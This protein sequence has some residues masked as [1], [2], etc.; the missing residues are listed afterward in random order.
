[1][2]NN[3]FRKIGK[4]KILNENILTLSPDKLPS[5]VGLVITSPPYPNAYEYW[6]YH[7]Y[8]M[9]WLGMNPLKVKEQEIGA[10]PHYFKKNPQDETDFEVQMSQCFKLLSQIMLEGSKACFLI[11][12]SIIHGRTIDNASLLKRAS[13]PHGFVVDGMIKRDILSTRKT[14]NPSHGK[15]KEEHLMVFSLRKKICR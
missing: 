9:Y 10:R 8:R 5:N 7:K 15:I 14:F 11:G 1:M 6:L 3:L 2:E 12:R 13:E 4:A